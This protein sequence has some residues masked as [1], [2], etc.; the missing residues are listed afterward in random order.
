MFRRSVVFIDDDESLL[1]FLKHTL[2]NR[3]IEVHCFHSHEEALEAIQDIF[4][5]IVFVDYQMPDGNGIGLL[6]KVR[7]L[8]PFAITIMLTG[9]GNEFIAVQ[10]MKAGAHDYLV[11]PVDCTHLLEVIEQSFKKYFSRILDLNGKYEYPISDIAIARYEFIRAVYSGIAKSIKTVCK[12]F[13]YSRQ[14][15][16]NYEKR[17]KLYGPVGLLKKK[18]FEKIPN[19]EIYR[20]DYKGKIASLDDFFKK[21]DD[22]QV[23]LEMLREAA[24]AAKPNI[25]EIS[26]K[27]GL[28]REAFYQIYR[29]FKSSGL[30]ALTEKKKGRPPK[31]S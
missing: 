30:F 8:V 9:E 20:R 22:V 15:F 29:R 12:F 4:P 25:C 23:K 27:Y 14:D 3:D 19:P 18:D 11:K 16:Y 24:T 5:G 13:N 1:V 28:T 2:E 26:Q 6:E 7:E 17:F 31:K 10:S 21:N